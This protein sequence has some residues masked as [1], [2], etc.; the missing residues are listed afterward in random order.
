[1]ALYLAAPYLKKIYQ[2]FIQHKPIHI[3]NYYQPAFTKKWQAIGIKVLKILIIADALFYGVKGSIDQGKQYGDNAPKPPLYGIYNTELVMRNNDTIPPLTTD[4][5]RWKQIII[6]S[7]NYAR[8][9][10][11]NDTLS[12]YNFKIDTVLKRAVVYSVRGYIKQNHF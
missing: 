5:S 11:M 12:N 10:L 2:A 1:M 4:T 7:N 8:I 6:Q 3:N 9:K